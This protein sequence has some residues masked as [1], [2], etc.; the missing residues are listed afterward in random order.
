MNRTKIVIMGA[1]GRDFHNFQ[2][3]YRDDPSVEVIAFTATQIPGIEDRIFPPELAGSH[4]PKGIP[5]LPEAKL[6]EI[7]GHH[8]VHQVVFAYSDIAIRT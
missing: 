1:A 2:V 3:C 4:Y 7:V 6:P 8:K 5:I